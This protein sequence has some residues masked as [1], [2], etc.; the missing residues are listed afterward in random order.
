MA[1]SVA[2]L[3]RSMFVRSGTGTAA[4]RTKRRWIVSQK[5]GPVSTP[6][7]PGSLGG[8]RFDSYKVAAAEC[9]GA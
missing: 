9:A 4:L 7:V 3:V 1:Q 5:G 2:G 6:R 8:K